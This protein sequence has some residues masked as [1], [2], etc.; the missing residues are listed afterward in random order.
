MGAGG[1]INDIIT[2]AVGTALL[3]ICKEEGFR[4]KKYPDKYGNETI[5]F[6]FNISSGISIYSARALAR[7]QVEELDGEL[8]KLQWY[9]GIDVIRRSVCLD[10][11]FNEGMQGLLKFPHMIS[12]LAQGDWPTASAECRVEDSKLNESRYAPLRKLL[13]IG[14]GQ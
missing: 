8:M 7:A 12:A 5:G 10:I 13:L 6:G 9:Q 14:G 11:A 1:V 3:R 2:D 4:S